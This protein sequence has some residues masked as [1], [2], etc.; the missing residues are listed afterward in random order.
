MKRQLIFLSVD[1]TTGKVLD[2]KIVDVEVAPPEGCTRMTIPQAVL[3][4]ALD[5]MMKGAMAAASKRPRKDA[6]VKG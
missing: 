2:S 3:D 6:E 5:G 1:A 4:H